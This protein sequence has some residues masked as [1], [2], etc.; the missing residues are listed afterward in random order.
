MA[1]APRATALRLAA[2]LLLTGGCLGF[3]LWGIDFDEAL[4]SLAAF[5]WWML[6]PIWS[7]YLTAHAMRAQRFRVLLPADAARGA[8][9]D[10]RASFSSLSIGY[11]ALNVIPFRLGEL[12]RPYLVR[13]QR[14]VS[15]GESLAVVVVE[16]IL[17]VAALLCMILATSLLVPLPTRLEVG[18]VDVLGLA[19]RVAGGV[20]LV[21]TLGLLGVL[22][23]GP[24][25][26][27]LVR[28]LPLGARVLPPVER[29]HG[30]VAALVRRPAAGAQAVALTV[31]LWLLTILAVKLQLHATQ[32]VPTSAGA[33]LTTWTATL[34]G[35]SVLPTPGFFGGFEAACATALQLLGAEKSAAAPFA[36]LLHLGQFVFT[37]VLGVAFL[38]VEGLSLRE[39][40][41]RS[42]E[43]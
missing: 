12:V 21:G 10:Y 4:A 31:G 40:V 26:F 28:G 35:M 39:V 6:L 9:L 23:A 22:V 11:L 25:L 13:E 16:R 29:F 8:P 27:P 5:D 1:A 19:Q 18:E 17:D 36:I 37:I 24:R 30:A 32:G 3:V 14:G 2:V 33:A 34:A 15:F 41:S 42:R 43:A 7:L 38:A 20:A